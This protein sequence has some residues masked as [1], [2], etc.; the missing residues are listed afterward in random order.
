MSARTGR[1]LGGAT[2]LL[3]LAVVMTAAI[4]AHAS[5][6]AQD[7]ADQTRQ[8]QA[9]CPGTA[10]PDADTA[11]LSQ[12]V[13]QALA[14]TTTPVRVPGL[15]VPGE[16]IPNAKTIVATG[17]QMGVPAGGQVIALATALQE[18]DLR[19][20]TGGDWDS[21]GLFQQRPS[22]GWGT[23]QQISDPVYASQKFYSALL[24][25]PNWQ[26]LP[27]TVAAQDVQKSGHP[28]AYAPHAA[29]ATAL[30]QAITPTLGAGAPAP[31][32]PTGNG[33]GCTTPAPA[34]TGTIPPGAIPAGYQIP[35]D[36]PPAV[37]T[38]IQWALSQLG[39]PYQW[40]G[41]CTDP[42]GADRAGRC[43]CSSLVQ[44]AYGV[45]GITVARTTY[46]Q[47]DQGTAVAA[48]PAALRPG[49]LVFTEGTPDHPEHVA[50]AIGQGLLVQAP[51][52]GAVVDVVEVANHGT[53]LA[54]RRVV[55]S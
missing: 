39:T 5:E 41:E 38:A 36:A 15:D 44:R 16:Q 8:T 42:H 31:A 10:L 6:L 18:S 45:A 2:L 1:L 21:V 28:D 49:D 24:A 20:L 48:D 51:H 23:A 19:N 33:S 35:P 37:R 9:P 53:L 7:Q 4:A 40:G 26:Q 29:L 50:L 3:V 22:Q 14:G 17:L 27:L 47:V 13:Q 46:D 12:Q 30:Q 25:V 43:D 11:Q 52:T 55:S 34:A 54:V 32:G